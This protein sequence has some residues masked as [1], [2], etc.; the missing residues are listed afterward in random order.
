MVETVI[1]NL[2]SLVLQKHWQCSHRHH[3]SNPIMHS[4]TFIFVVRLQANTLN[5]VRDILVE[6]KSA[7]FHHQ[8]W[9][10][11][12]DGVN[13]CHFE[14]H[15]ESSTSSIPAQWAH[16]DEFVSVCVSCDLFRKNHMQF[17][18][19]LLPLCTHLGWRSVDRNGLSERHNITH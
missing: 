3:L 5:F 14:V 19:L 11:C 15:E 1:T 7:A 17:C 6:V 2:R 13:S 10:G 4:S 8:R 9:K 16:C 12:P 18:S